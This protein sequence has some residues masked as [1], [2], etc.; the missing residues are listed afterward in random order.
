MA[1]SLFGVQGQPLL[2][3]IFKLSGKKHEMFPA[4]FVNGV[5]PFGRLTAKGSS[6]LLCL[7]SCGGQLFALL[8][9]QAA[10]FSSASSP[11]AERCFAASAR[12]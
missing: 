6:Q 9:K 7:R 1:Q 11:M 5:Q 3:Y 2:F 4:A 12:T 8:S 10:D